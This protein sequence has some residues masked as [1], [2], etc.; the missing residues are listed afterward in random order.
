L[1]R[2]IVL[3]AFLVFMFSA[4]LETYVRTPVRVEGTGAGDGFSSREPYF[5]E[6]V[7]TYF[8]ITNSTYP[9]LNITLTSTQTVHVILE[10][11]PKM[12]SFFIESNSSATSTVLTFSDFEPSTAYYRYQDGELMENFTTDSNGVYSY[13]QDVS[14]W[15]HVF[16]LSEWVDGDPPATPQNNTLYVDD[17]YVD[18][19]PPYFNTIQGAIN[20]APFGETIYVYAGNYHEHLTIDKSLTLI[21]EGPNSAIIDGDGTGIVVYVT[22]GYV[23]ISGFKITN[24]EYGVW[25]PYFGYGV[26]RN[27]DVSNNKGVGI[28]FNWSYYVTITDNKV[29][30]NGGGAMWLDSDRYCTIE[31][32][33]I[34]SNGVGVM[35]GYAPYGNSIINNT[36]SNNGWWRGISLGTSFPDPSTVLRDNKLIGNDLVICF[37]DG[38]PWYPRPAA[39]WYLSLDID[40]SNTVGGKPVY[41]LKNQKNLVI[42][43]TTFPNVGQ[44]GLVNSE[45]IT[46]KDTNLSGELLFAFTT[47]STIENVSISRSNYGV[48]LAYSNRNKITQTILTSTMAGIVLMGSSSNAIMSNVISNSG[49]GVAGW[50]P[51]GWGSQFNIISDNTISNNEYY[52]FSLDGYSTGNMIYHNNIKNNIVQAYDQNPANNNWHHPDLLEGNYW[53][54]YPGVD[55]GSGTGKHSIAGDGIGDTNIPWPGPGYDY[56][57][58]VREL[59]TLVGTN[60]VFTEP[61]TGTTVKFEEVTS[62]G[63]TNVTTSTTGPPPPTG[64]R[65]VVGILGQPIY[66]DISTT[67]AYSGTITVAIRYDET[68][69]SASED[70]IKLW[71]FNNGPNDITWYVDTTNN[72]IYGN[73]THLSLFIITEPY[74]I[75]TIDVDPDTLNLRSE[76]QWITAY[77]Q[78]P[79]GYN[80]ADI[81]ATTILLNGTISP[82]L[83]P[84]YGFVTNSSEYLVDHNNDGISERM[85]KFDRATV[86]SFI[87]NQ[88]IRYDNVALTLTGNLLD[89]IPFEGTDK[90]FVNYAGDANNDGTINVLDAGVI[91]AHWGTDDSNTDFNKDGIV[92]ILDLGILNVNWGQTVPSTTP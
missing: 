7:G 88:G 1:E 52:G 2:K 35:E 85:V 5:V 19:V 64:F 3:M 48:N 29:Y 74:I 80:P 50:S 79:Q 26:I 33:F 92:N 10:S 76:G 45:N 13:A 81:N 47:D 55:D 11:I 49:Y 46:V 58:F 8:E 31:N 40:T 15:H 63:T 42:D 83:D 65:I 62:S 54:D 61:S 53:S 21:G 71:Q 73:T 78:L 70:K 75:A 9:Y 89:G 34:Y 91:N 86:E 32:N 18:P 87:Y 90:I 14:R 37:G 44:L 84:K 24:G 59:N 72:I 39:S 22:A 68:Q 60:I 25:A 12:V 30:N 17:D 43:P 4:T 69:V 36:I 6:A 77:I 66:Y 23:S 67:A 16:M 51:V 57:P 82:V 41:Y 20:Y 28:Q 38:R 27:C 56:Y